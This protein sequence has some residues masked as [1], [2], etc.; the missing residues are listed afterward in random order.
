MK[1]NEELKS[2]VREKYGQ[3]AGQSRER[4]PSSCCG[5]SSCCGDVEYSVTAD[6]YSS[7]PGYNPDADLGLGC[8]LPTEYAMIKEGDVV[9]DLGSGAGNDCFVARSIVGESGRVIGVDMTEKMIEKARANAARLGYSNVEFIL[10]DIEA[11]P[12]EESTADVVVSNCV[13]NLVPDKN[14]AF[15]ETYRI[16]KPGGHFSISDIVVQGEMP[17]A[18]RKDAEMYAGCVAGA[19]QK[20]NYLDALRKAG[21]KNVRIQKEKSI[22]LPEPLIDKYLT[23]EEAE[24]FG[25]SFGIF[26]VTVYGEK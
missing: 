26:S 24:Q 16:L 22:A 3:I 21:F 1:T 12:L 14:K 11:I 20:D 8:G 9:V 6:D 15:A 2:M 4:N 23:R 13:M 10:G 17:E 5:G 25:K 18:L 19:I 7:L